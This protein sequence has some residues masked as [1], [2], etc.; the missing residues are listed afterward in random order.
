M[1]SKEN[2]EMATERNEAEATLDWEDLQDRYKR[3]LADKINAQRRNLKDVQQARDDG[4][5]YVAA[6]FIEVYDDLLRALNAMSMGGT[7][8]DH[9][10]GMQSIHSK[11]L[12]VLKKLEIEGFRS[13]G[14]QFSSQRMD[15]VAQIPS[16]SLPPGTVAAEFVQGFTR[17]GK[18]LR[19]AKVGVAVQGFEDEPDPA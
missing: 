14:E 17:R 4:E 15:A 5:G 10:I 16:K 12:G 18:L 13:Q 7:A 19:A 1:A 8:E 2:A 6:E 3:A 9:V 11:F